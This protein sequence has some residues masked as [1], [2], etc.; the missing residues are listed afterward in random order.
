MMHIQIQATG[1]GLND[2]LI[3]HVQRRL[4][5]ALSRSADR[6]SRVMVRLS[7]INGPKGGVDKACRIEVRLAGRPSVVIE[8]I[9]SD[10]YTAVDRAAGRAGRTVLRRLALPLARRRAA[11]VGQLDA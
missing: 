2:P 3:S 9:Q 10:I 5:Y 1:I 8:D 11:L 4:C 7:D 6:V